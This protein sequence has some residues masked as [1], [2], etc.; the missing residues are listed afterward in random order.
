MNPED[1]IPL[2]FINHML[3][4]Y[5]DA[6]FDVFC[7]GLMILSSQGQGFCRALTTAFEASWDGT[8]R[9]PHASLMRPCPGLV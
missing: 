2:D 7:V 9:R 5:L 8:A 1:S 4:S 6:L 3:Y